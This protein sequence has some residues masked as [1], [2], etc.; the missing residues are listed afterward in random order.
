M[1]KHR[2]SA[3]NFV[4]AH[5]RAFVKHFVKLHV[6]SQATETGKHISYLRCVEW[7]SGWTFADGPKPYLKL[8]ITEMRLG[9]LENADASNIQ[10]SSTT[11]VHWIGNSSDPEG[12]LRVSCTSQI[13]LSLL[14]PD[15]LPIPMM[16]SA[17]E[18]TLEVVLKVS[19]GLSLLSMPKA[20]TRLFW[21]FPIILSQI[22]VLFDVY[23]H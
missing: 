1:F 10:C 15:T 6:Y 2:M 3:A 14:L 18:A 8:E 11:L 20:S 23:R 4:C 12:S 13:D 21:H 17:L 19:E 22:C 9:N 5:L 16:P 7:G